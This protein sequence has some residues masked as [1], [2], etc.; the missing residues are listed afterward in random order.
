VVPGGWSIGV[1]MVFYLFFPALVI[2]KGG[3]RLYLSIGFAIYLINLV[4]V[5]PLYEAALIDFG[6]EQLVGA[7]L[8]DQFFNQ[9][10]IFLVGMTSY[11]VLKGDKLDLPATAI[12]MIWIAS[13]LFLKYALHT[14]GSPFFWLP[15]F[16]A[17]AITYAILKYGV[18]LK[19]LA[20]FGE[21]SYSAYLSHFAVIDL[22]KFVYERSG[23][24]LNSYGGFAGGLAMVIAITWATGIAMRYCVEIPSSNVGKAIIRSL[25]APQS[26]TSPGPA[27]QGNVGSVP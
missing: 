25:Y 14:N 23:L 3:P 16:A 10:P 22:V 12:V 7:F 20:S 8:Y 18:S 2:L 11:R 27:P 5:K 9:A 21:I 4:L 15:V 26:P 17:A 1:E 13:S 19:P 6:H 24:D